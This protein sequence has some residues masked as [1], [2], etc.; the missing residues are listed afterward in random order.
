MGEED[1]ALFTKNIGEPF[2]SWTP[3]SKYG[4]PSTEVVDEPVVTN[5]RKRKE[6]TPN[7]KN[8]GKKSRNSSLNKD[9]E[10][11]DA[12]EHDHSKSAKNSP[13]V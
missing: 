11:T 6:L 1:L 4:D 3:L 8:K 9:D 5:Q 2:Y 7:E 13:T 10:T 12:E